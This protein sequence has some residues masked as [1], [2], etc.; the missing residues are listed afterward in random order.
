MRQMWK[1]AALVV[2]ALQ[3]AGCVVMKT[4]REDFAGPGNPP[5][6]T[7]GGYAYRS[8]P[9]NVPLYEDLTIELQRAPVFVIAFADGHKA[10]SRGIT[11]NMLG[12]HGFVKDSFRENEWTW[13][14]NAPG[15]IGWM[16]NRHLVYR[17]GFRG[18]R[19]AEE[20]HIESCGETFQAAFGSSDG[21]RTF[22]FPLTKAD[23][24]QLFGTVS[25]KKKLE[26][27]LTPG[28]L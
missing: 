14:R 15:T 9:H 19:T 11:E 25:E 17:F 23:L 10:D 21:V 7:A 4:W 16:G 3:G 20:L 5:A 18:A 27:V 26:V 22:D 24:E 1:C 6:V 13:S 2:L 12:D 8:A 28:C